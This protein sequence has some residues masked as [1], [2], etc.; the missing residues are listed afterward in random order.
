MGMT[1][2]AMLRGGAVN[3]SGRKPWDWG[4]IICSNLEE[5]AE[6]A[7]AMAFLSPRWGLIVREAI[8]LLS[9]PAETGKT[10]MLALLL[11]RQREGGS[12]AGPSSPAGR[13]SAPKRA[14]GSGR[15]ASRR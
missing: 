15:C 12:W 8:T 7:S 10:A 11:H 14:T 1:R 2:P 6:A 5:A 9:A 13:S 4:A 3:S